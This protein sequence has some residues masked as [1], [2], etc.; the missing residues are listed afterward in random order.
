MR[1][2][3]RRGPI[4]RV[5]QTPAFE[6]VRLVLF[7]D[8]CRV[9]YFHAS[10]SLAPFQ[11]ALWAA[12]GFWYSR[13]SHVDRDIIFLGW[14]HKDGPRPAGRPWLLARNIQSPVSRNPCPYRHGLRIH[15][16]FL[17]ALGD[18]QWYRMDPAGRENE[19]AL[20]RNGFAS[21]TGADGESDF[22]SAFYSAGE[23]R[24]LSNDRS[25]LSIDATSQDRHRIVSNR[26]FVC[27]HCLDPGTNRCGS[28]TGR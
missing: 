3:E 8:Q 26:A 14:P 16:V 17:G 15:F 2:G 13:R 25:R 9:L 20:V 7:F 18:E 19:P 28:E 27:G 5:E 12:L 4:W 1:F 11:P 22:D 21:G 23:L 10:L 6:N 24:D